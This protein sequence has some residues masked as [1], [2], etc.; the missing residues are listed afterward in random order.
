MVQRFVIGQFHGKSC[1]K[2]VLVTV[3]NSSCPEKEIRT[4]AILDD[5][6][7]HSLARTELVDKFG[8]QSEPNPYDLKS[9]AG[10]V[11]MK[12]RISDGFTVES[13]DSSTILD[14]PSVIECKEIP[15]DRGEIPTPSV[16]HKHE[17]M[18]AIAN[19]IP[20]MD[21][22]SDI[23]LFIG[24][25]VPE[26]NNVLDQRLGPWKAPFAQRMRLGWVIVGDVFYGATMCQTSSTS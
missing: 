17:H 16:A 18:E 15:G 3:S 25:N 24:H 12:G 19:D 1:A 9:C 22:S 13:L 26:A 4:Y 2:I 8:I 21:E 14:L 23:L 20:Q 6:A 7:T 5:Q 11:V 10:S